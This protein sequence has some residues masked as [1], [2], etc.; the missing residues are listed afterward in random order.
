[1]HTPSLKHPSNNQGMQSMSA[2]FQRDCEAAREL[3]QEMDA[4][5]D[6]F[7][8][9]DNGPADLNPADNLV[10]VRSPKGRSETTFRAGIRTEEHSYRDREGY[11]ETH[12]SKEL[13]GAHYQRTDY[14]SDGKANRQV[15]LSYVKGWD[16]DSITK[17]V[18]D[19]N[20]TSVA[21]ASNKSGY[22][23]NFRPKDTIDSCDQGWLSR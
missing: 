22:E 15:T 19:K 8:K 5:I 21:R 6:S 4:V 9:A 16:L 10:H 11:W 14:G 17:T 1:M 20:G 3:R 18:I 7:R 23:V 13:T 2:R 12:V